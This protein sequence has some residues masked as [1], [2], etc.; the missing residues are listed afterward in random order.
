[1]VSSYKKW[2]QVFDDLS[3]NF[4]VVLLTTINIIIKLFKPSSPISKFYH[5]RCEGFFFNEE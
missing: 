4:Q 2:A 1:M 3:L 5:S